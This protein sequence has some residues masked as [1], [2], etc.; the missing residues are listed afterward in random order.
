ME[1]QIYLLVYLFHLILLPNLHSYLTLTS[2][3]FT[4]NGKMHFI[5]FLS[6]FYFLPLETM[7]K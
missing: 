3:E 7:R 2:L 4:K 1:T 5:T 6:T